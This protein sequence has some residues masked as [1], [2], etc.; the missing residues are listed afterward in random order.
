[1]TEV[2]RS[3]DEGKEI[4]PAGLRFHSGH[5][6]VRL[7]SLDLALVGPT[8]F[9]V[10]FAGSMAGISL[11]REFSLLRPGETAW[12]FTT[13]KGRHLSQISPIGGQVLAVNSDVREDPSQLERSPYRAGWIMC[14]RSPD[15]PYRM[16]SL[17]SQEPDLL[18]LDRTCKRMTSVLGT[19][20]R[21]PYRDG[22]WEPQFG[23]G[24]SDE[25]W[26]AL[27][28]DLFSASGSSPRSRVLSG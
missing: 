13:A 23:D 17:L 24:F 26:E 16:R 9:A 2:A 3:I 22:G 15:I 27:R 12:T 19:A 4:P 21:L 11:P 10:S 20:L 1:M 7:V 14:M 25:E 6:W 18:G 8:G 28:R 5:T